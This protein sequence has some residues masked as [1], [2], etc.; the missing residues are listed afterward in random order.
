MVS[1][2]LRISTVCPVAF[3]SKAVIVKLYSLDVIVGIP[4]SICE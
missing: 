2:K 4:A 1:I 3:K